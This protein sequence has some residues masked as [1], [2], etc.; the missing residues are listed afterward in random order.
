MWASIGSGIMRAAR[1]A[2]NFLARGAVRDPMNVGS[3]ALFGLPLVVSSAQVRTPQWGARQYEVGNLAR[4]RLSPGAASEMTGEQ[5]KGASMKLASSV[6]SNDDLLESLRVYGQLEKQANEKIA[7]RKG[8]AAADIADQLVRAMGLEVSH[9]G[10]PASSSAA[11]ATRGGVSERLAKNL[12]DAQEAEK[13]HLMQA[14]NMR[15]EQKAIREAAQE[16]RAAQ[17]Q[18]WQGAEEVRR[19]EAQGWGRSREAREAEKA[20][21]EAEQLNLSK[22]EELRKQ[23][24][25]KWQQSR[26]QREAERHEKEMKKWTPG[27]LLMAG[28]GIGSAATLVGAGTTAVGHAAGLAQEKIRSLGSNDRFNSMLKVDPSLREEP[29]ARAYFQILD[30]ASPY[31]SSEPYLA[32]ATVQQMVNTPSLSSSGVPAIRPEQLTQILKA[33][34]A[35]QETRFPFMGRKDPSLKDIASLGG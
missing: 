11:R 29:K 2:G 5:F 14:K 18:G 13:I 34:Q 8:R 30:R 17:A 26:E 28:L 25:H 19:A 1:G 35:R 33:E 24:A 15:E 10:P 6:L 12:S 22:Q 9:V 23:E 20:R 16:L 4:G 7:A 32:A 31:I 3:A 21:R 27:Q